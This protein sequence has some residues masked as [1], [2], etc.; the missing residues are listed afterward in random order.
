M[1]V[2]SDIYTRRIVVGEGGIGTNFGV[3]KDTTV[4]GID[5]LRRSHRD[6]DNQ[7]LDRH[8][9]RIFPQPYRFTFILSSAISCHHCCSLLKEFTYFAKSVILRRRVV[10]L[11][12]L[13]VVLVRSGNIFM[14]ECLGH[15]PPPHE[16]QTSEADK[17]LTWQ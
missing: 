5:Q 3:Y 12:Q 10:I 1:E 2:G 11:R 15:P 16:Q 4:S 9:L 8:S 13:P 17:E 6:A 7:I 14:R